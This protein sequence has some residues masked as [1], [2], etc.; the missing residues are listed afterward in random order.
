MSFQDSG[1]SELTLSDVIPSDAGEVICM[2]SNAAGQ[3]NGSAT[4]EVKCEYWP[5]LKQG[6]VTYDMQH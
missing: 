2:A 3:V 1:R 5:E 6:R 4:L